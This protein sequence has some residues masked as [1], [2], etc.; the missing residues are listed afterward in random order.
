MV[1]TSA[2]GVRE[3]TAGKA[4]SRSARC[5]AARSAND[6]DKPCRRWRTLAGD[7]TR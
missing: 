1:K 5:C 4:R 3:S 2:R 6:S 7:E